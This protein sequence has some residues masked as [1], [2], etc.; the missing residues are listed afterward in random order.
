M[1]TRR[2]KRC[3]RVRVVE[4]YAKGFAREQKWAS[5]GGDHQRAAALNRV[6]VV[7][8]WLYVNTTRGDLTTVKPLPVDGEVTD[9]PEAWFTLL[10]RPSTPT[11]AFFIA[12]AS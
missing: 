9:M 11:H 5:T 1:Q 3:E 12:G 7:V 10:A 8:L 2:K 6:S 4:G